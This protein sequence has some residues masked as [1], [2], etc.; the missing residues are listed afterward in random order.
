[1][2]IYN[3]LIEMKKQRAL[4]EQEYKNE[5]AKMDEEIVAY[6][7][8][9]GKYSK[10]KEEIKEVLTKLMTTYEG[11]EYIYLPVSHTFIAEIRDGQFRQVTNRPLIIVA[12]DQAKESYNE[13][14]VPLLMDGKAIILQGTYYEGSPIYF[15][16]DYDQTISFN[17]D[18]RVPYVRN[19]IDMVI[20][21]RIENNL[22]NIDRATLEALLTKFLVENEQA[23]K[24]YKEKKQAAHDS[25]LNTDQPK[26]LKKERKD[27]IQ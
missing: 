3:K 19:F 18:I 1:M 10:F 12:A 27:S 24:E 21:Y 17:G 26:T 2:Q 11:E 22:E 9:V 20:D 6:T 5:L 23:I 13:D 4:Q 25:L 14:L 15:Y 16:I 7:R 8:Q